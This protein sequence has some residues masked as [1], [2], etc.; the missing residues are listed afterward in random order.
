[1]VDKKI[2]LKHLGELE[3]CIKQLSNHKNCTVRQLLSDFDLRWAVERGLQLAIQNVL[4]ISSH[5]L[6][7]TGVNGLDD[8]TSMIDQM[9]VK[10]IIPEDFAKKIRG[11]A[12]LRNV[13]VH[14]YVDIDTKK[15][16]SYVVAGLDD[17]KKFA[18]YIADYLARKQ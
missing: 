17:F 5:I 11:M 1:M 13:L 9:G 2:I 12:G 8:Y 6:V 15:L 4:D 18:K 16:H 14:D 3:K 7:E 10:G